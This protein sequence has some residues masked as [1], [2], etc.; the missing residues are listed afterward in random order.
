MEHVQVTIGSISRE[1]LKNFSRRQRSNGRQC[2]DLREDI[3]WQHRIVMAAYNDRILTSEVYSNIFRILMEIYVAE[4]PEQAIEFLQEVEPYDTV[5][6][7]TG[8]LDASPENIKYV[9]LAL[10]EDSMASGMTILSRAH[11]LYL[12][13]VGLNLISAIDSH[14]NQAHQNVKVT[15]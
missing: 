15:A 4:N 9:N 12:K 2:W 8:W 11:K 10:Q 5:S 1:M 3:T 6:Q 14:I 13:E 7:L